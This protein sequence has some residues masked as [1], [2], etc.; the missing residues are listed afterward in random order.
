MQLTVGMFRMVLLPDGNMHMEFSGETYAL[1]SIINRL[2]IIEQ[3][4]TTY[5]E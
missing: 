2:Y 3:T 1:C 5:I 4:N